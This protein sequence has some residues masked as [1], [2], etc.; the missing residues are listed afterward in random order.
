M[1]KIL[2]LLMIVTLTKIGFC[3]YVHFP[4]SN[5]V[6]ALDFI[7]PEIY[8]VDGDTTIND[9]E[10]KKY[11]IT[12][13]T[14]ITNYSLF[15][16]LRED[17]LTKKIYAFTTSTSVENLL[18]DFSASLSDTISVFSYCW[19]AYGSLNVKVAAVDS[20]LIQGQYRKR[21]KV[22][23]LD[24]NNN[25]FDEYWIEGIGST[26]GV[27][28]SGISGATSF[29]TGGLGLPAL[30]CFHQ[31]D[32]LLYDNPFFNGCFPNS[33]VGFQSSIKSNPIQIFPNPTNDILNITNPHQISTYQI[34]QMDGKLI[35]QGNNFPIDISKFTNGIYFLKITTKNNQIINQKIIK[36]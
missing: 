2:L 14:T 17:T 21:M 11:Y 26:C 15:G 24:I 30:V 5:A 35:T 27:F 19:G 36:Q 8:L 28:F 3:Q 18:Y 33:G 9:V 6:W 1:K 22:V 29:Q 7:G 20:I 32:S 16:F 31:N 10:Y 12:T 23:N 34:Y 13:D 25:G 4:D